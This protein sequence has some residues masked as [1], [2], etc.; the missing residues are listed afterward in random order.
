MIGQGLAEVVSEMPT[1]RK[2]V[3]HNA[4][5]KRRSERKSSKNITSWSLNLSRECLLSRSSS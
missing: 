1:Q 5:E 2:A 4:H 3:G